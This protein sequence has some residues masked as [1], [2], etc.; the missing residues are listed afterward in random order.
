[1]W[2]TIL[3]ALHA[4]AGTV[5]LLAGLVA[6]RGRTWFAVYFWAL[7]ATVVTLAAAVAQEWALLDPAARLLFVTFT[8]LGVVMVWLARNAHGPRYVDRVGFTL[9]AL[10][11]AFVVITV[12][13]AGAP[14]AVVVGAGVVVAVA[15]HFVLRAVKARSAAPARRAVPAGTPRP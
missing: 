13:N 8:G 1:M 11:D 3:I 15:G 2:H 9:V 10:F 6:H 5:A 4:S 14:V 12:L 7:V